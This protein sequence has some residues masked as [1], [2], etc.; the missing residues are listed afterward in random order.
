MKLKDGVIKPDV[1]K[2][3]YEGYSSNVDFLS[4]SGN[5]PE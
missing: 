4:S 3:L 5:L 2:L 1:I